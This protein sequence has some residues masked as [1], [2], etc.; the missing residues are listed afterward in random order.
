MFQVLCNNKPADE[1][2]FP[3]L[4]GKG[5]ISSKFDTFD[6]AKD[7]VTLWLGFEIDIELNQE[8]DYSGYG[9]TIKIVQEFA[10]I[11]LIVTNCA[12]CPMCYVDDKTKYNYCKSAQYNNVIPTENLTNK[13]IPKICPYLDKA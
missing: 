2:G 4:K 10:T 7:F 13:T 3:E 9:D 5:W 12:E 11:K 6:K 1:N 8:F